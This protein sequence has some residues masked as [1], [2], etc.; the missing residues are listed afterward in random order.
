MKMHSVSKKD[1]ANS[2]QPFGDTAIASWV[3]RD[4]VDYSSVPV[5]RKRGVKRQ[6]AYLVKQG[7][8]PDQRETNE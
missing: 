7:I 2:L 5:G 3:L 6:M 8:E 4:L 1:A